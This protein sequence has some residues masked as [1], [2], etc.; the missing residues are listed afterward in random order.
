MLLLAVVLARAVLAWDRSCLPLAAPPRESQLRGALL[1]RAA[2]LVPFGSRRERTGELAV[3]AG[4]GIDALDDYFALYLP[5]LVLALIVPVVV[6]VAVLADDWI[7]AAIIIFTIPL[8]P[9]FMALVGAVTGE[10]TERELQALQRLAGHFLDVV[11]GLPTLKVFGRSRAQVAAIVTNA[12]GAALATRLTFLS[13]LVLELIATLAVASA[14][15][16]GL[17]VEPAIRPRG[18][19][20]PAAPGSLRRKRTITR[21]N[22]DGGRRAG[23]RDHQCP[24]TAGRA[25][26]PDPAK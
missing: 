20:A 8:I 18:L 21:A 15:A 2:E 7:S 9:V 17:R 3:L 13:S 11:A 4:P 23:A 1:R 6:V 14:V 25:L 19:F 5:Q 22:G 10:R 16:I 26:L 24:G 12:T